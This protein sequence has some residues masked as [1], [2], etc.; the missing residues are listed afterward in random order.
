MNLDILRTIFSNCFSS[1]QTNRTN[2]WVAKDHSGY[3]SVIKLS[4]G[5]I[6]EEVALTIDVPPCAAGVQI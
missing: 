4:I 6:V 1:S 5:F 2:D 3:I